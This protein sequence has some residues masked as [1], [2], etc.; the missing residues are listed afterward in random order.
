MSKR[1]LQKGFTLVEML[2]VMSIISILVIGTMKLNANMMSSDVN[3]QCYYKYAQLVSSARAEAFRSQNYTAICVELS[4]N[5]N[6]A[7]D[8]EKHCFLSVLNYNSGAKRFEATGAGEKFV[9]VPEGR[10][11]MYINKN[12]GASILSKKLEDISSFIMIFSPDGQLVT[13][14]DGSQ[15]SWEAPKQKSLNKTKIY[16]AYGQKYVSPY[17]YRKASLIDDANDRK[18]FLAGEVELIR[19]NPQTGVIY[20]RQ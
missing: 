15:V 9:K 10:A 4:P 3:E 7:L 13:D 8:D 5:T 17:N 1:K 16:T 2:V 11:F 18:R 20:D 12:T 6:D 19:I 14:V